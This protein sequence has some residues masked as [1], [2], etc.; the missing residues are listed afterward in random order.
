MGEIREIEEIRETEEEIRD[1]K[2]KEFNAS[3]LSKIKPET[4][5][6]IE[7]AENFWNEL[8]MGMVK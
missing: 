6:T 8:F 2:R 4:D 3:E 1:R 7:E 5:I